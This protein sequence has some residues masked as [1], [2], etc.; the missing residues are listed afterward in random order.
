MLTV[1]RT[2]SAY[3][4]FAFEIA[5]PGGLAVDG[6]SRCARA[7]R[8]GNADLLVLVPDRVGDRVVWIADGRYDL[9]SA[10]PDLRGQG[11]PVRSRRADEALPMAAV[12]RDVAV[13]LAPDPLPLADGVGVLLR[14]P[15]H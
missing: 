10:E 11:L 6:L 8:T 7:L 14:T 5:R 12:V 3:D 4:Q 9:V 13:V 15:Y 1:T 2:P